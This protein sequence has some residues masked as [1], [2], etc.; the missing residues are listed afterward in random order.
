MRAPLAAF[1][2]ISVLLAAC[3]GGGSTPPPQ[4]VSIALSPEGATTGVGL[5]LQMS[6]T[7]TWS[8]GTTAGVTDMALWNSDTPSVATVGST[9]LVSGV[10]LGST[11]ISA[12]IGSIS[13]SATLSVT[14]NVWSPAG[15]LSMARHSHTATL[16]ANGKV[17]VAGGY[18]ADFITA[19]AELYDPASRT[20][21]PTGSLAVARALHTATL[22]PDGKVLVTGG[23]GN[24]A[25]SAVETASSELYDPATGTWSPTGNLSLPR[26]S[27]SA[28]LLPDGKVL[29]AGGAHTVIVGC[30]ASDVS[31]NDAELYDPDAGTWT[32]TG[33]LAVARHL[34][35]ATLL[36]DGEVLV[37]GGYGNVEAGGPGP[38]F[39]TATTELYDP[40]TGRWSPGGALSAP[41]VGH[42]A[43]LLSGGSVLVAAGYATPAITASAVLYDPIAAAWS[44]TGS[45]ASARL[46][47]T[48]T[49]LPNG[50]V[51]IAG[52]YDSPPFPANAELFDPAAGTWSPAGS[53][54]TARYS[55]T[56]TLLPNGVVLVVGGQASSG[57]L[58]STE[59][60]W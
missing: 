8:D 21:T 43:T 29:V 30:C 48:A 58:A 10:A 23:L 24:D 4:L 49:L 46:G 31:Y 27:H 52:G 45:L 14:T 12:T 5:S 44:P 33:A 47:H 50:R 20:W 41:R 22:L 1:A 51:L 40:A 6:A 55:H 34:H 38:P 26:H 18:T 15:A 7:G 42:S 39:V 54:A 13:A 25:G 60:Y 28:T 2:C 36:P 59:L 11:A 57:D 9:G 35:T 3:G 32:P 19:S 16:L 53:L 37:A 17:L 56:A